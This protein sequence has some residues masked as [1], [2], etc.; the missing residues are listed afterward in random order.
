M[1]FA[2]KMM[3]FGAANGHRFVL[4]SCRALGA[5]LRISIEMAACSIENS[6]KRFGHLNRHSTSNLMNF[7]PNT[8]DF[9][10]PFVLKTMN[11]H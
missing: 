6:A 1:I 11:L 10:V 8:M 4:P 5:T 2:L 7:V 9:V 3:E